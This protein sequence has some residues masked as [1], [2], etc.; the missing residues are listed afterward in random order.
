[1]S[2][3]CRELPIVVCSMI[4]EQNVKAEASGTESR[5]LGI[6]GNVYH[7]KKKSLDFI[8]CSMKRQSP[9]KCTIKLYHLTKF[10]SGDTDTERDRETHQDLLFIPT[11][12]RN[13]N[14]WIPM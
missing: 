11:E 6:K 13:L 5:E 10:H 9:Y 1:M 8:L 4:R 2:L 14:K 7:N 12:F 3:L